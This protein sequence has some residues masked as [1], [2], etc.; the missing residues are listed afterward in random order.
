MSM[1]G[2]TRMGESPRLN[3][4]GYH[5]DR[6][7]A[8]PV[9]AR[10]L[11]TA[12]L[13]V[14]A[15]WLAIAAE[16]APPTLWYAQPAVKWTDA[17]P[18]G[19]G[20][21]GAMVF[22]GL[23][24]ERIQFNES[25]LWTGRPHDY[26]RAGAR[27]AL[28]EIRRLLLAGEQAAAQKLAKEKFI[29]DPDRQKAYQPFGDLRLHFAGHESAANYRRELDLDAAVARVTYRVGEITF[30]REVFASH[31]D[32]V[33]VVRLT[34]DR[35][36]QLTFTLAVTSP[37]KSARTTSLGTDSLVLTGEVEIGGLRFESRTRAVVA[38]GHVTTRDG[39]LTVDAADS[40][41]LLTV[42]ATSFKNY[43][44]IS[45]DP[46]VRCAEALAA[47]GRKWHG[48]PARDDFDYD[49]F[50]SAHLA[51]HR[52]L[53]RRV[54]LDLGATDRA[55]LP[56]DQRLA[57]ARRAGLDGDPALAALHFAY[58][59]YLLIASSRPGGQPANLQG[60]WNE[61]LAPPWDSKWTTNINVEMNY[62]P[63]ELT[64]LSECHTPLFDLIDD[65]AVSGARTA[66]EQ[67]GAGGWVLHHNTD[68]W[69]A[70]APVNGLDGIW[71]TGGAWLCFHLWEHWLFTGDRDFL[72]HR[73]YPAMKS[74]A[75]FFAD[76]L[77]KDPKTGWLVTFPAYSPEQDAAKGR[78]LVAGPTMDNQLIRA[79]FNSVIAAAAVLKTDAAF[80][81]TIS[82][83]RAQ[84]PPNQIGRHGQLQ[85]W[86]DDVDRPNNAHRHMSPLW[87]L[88]PGADITPA[89]PKIFAAAKTLL[90]WRGEGSTGWSYAW[91]IPLWARVGDGEFAYRQFAALLTKRTL[92]NLFDLCG[93]F[94]IDGNF[95]AT[96]GLA[97]MLLQ[98][99]QLTAGSAR[100]PILDLLPALPRAWPAGSVTGLCA[101]GGFEVDLTWR[102]GALVRAVIRSK[103]GRACAVRYRDHT[104]D[105]PGAPG[106]T[107]VLD[108]DLH[109]SR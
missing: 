65:L 76:T 69:R 101:R 72:A 34:A 52:S 26:V 23:A 87:A 75:Q 80:A 93:P 66:R 50:L 107:L 61:E 53:F 64:N 36:G 20:H 96:A 41:V 46:S 43:E 10:L 27:E 47:L 1:P 7:V 32:N 14:A 6:L 13:S 31:P 15:S 100:V 54:T 70:T 9:K 18:V 30:R 73:A 71:P 45:A 48:R 42:A 49:A 22:G 44:D 86:L 81:E 106:Q 11:C 83:L 24:D 19:N 108:G 16:P 37:H 4:C 39:T 95:G 57:E 104:L 2:T 62:W 38:G 5:R 29:S 55:R 40:V 105:V 82:A 84:L 77:V 25:T 12:L 94:Q 89:D 60:I 103:L 91:R 102:D 90:T 56:T 28:P 68:L 85:E 78:A 51:D 63:A 8:A 74:A 3:G 33:L 79:L 58:G 99:H 21:L 17:L 92:P 109:L 67:Y 97:E 98:S 88:Y 59:R 35:P